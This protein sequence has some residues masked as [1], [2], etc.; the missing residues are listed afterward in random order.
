MLPL[1][2]EL[3][4]LVGQPL[5][6]IVRRGTGTQVEWYLIRKAVEYG[7]VVPEKFGTYLRDVVGGH[8]EDPTPGLH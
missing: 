2:I 5:F 4:R 6:E 8:V 7:Y 3:A 1:S